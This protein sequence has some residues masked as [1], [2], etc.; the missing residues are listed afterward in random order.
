[1]DYQPVHYR[2]VYLDDEDIDD[3]PESEEGREEESDKISLNHQDGDDTSSCH[4]QEDHDGG[5]HYS[6][7]SYHYSDDHDSYSEDSDHDDDTKHQEAGE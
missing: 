6:D 4:I 1:M 7:E 3:P 2:K 5:D